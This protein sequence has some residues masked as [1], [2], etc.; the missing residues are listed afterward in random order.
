[1]HIYGAYVNQKV[2]QLHNEKENF[3]IQ[4]FAKD[5]N[6]V[7]QDARVC[8]APIRFGAGLKGKLI[9]AMKNGTP[10]V[11]TS[12]GAEGLFGD[13]WGNGFVE[14]NPQ[15]FVDKAVTLYKEERIW[16]EK[17]N[18][19]FR[20]LNER[21][22]NDEHQSNFIK[23]LNHVMASLEAH[24]LQN[25]T[26]QMLLHHHLQSTKYLSRWIEEKNKN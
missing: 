2:N 13:F 24:R 21:F 6:E 19:G 23:R 16:E 15:D 20:L 18:N 14:D 17:Q 10:C 26:G 1:M 9:D 5:V 3:L 7:M 8:L 12:I 22:N 11:T 4:G 25:F